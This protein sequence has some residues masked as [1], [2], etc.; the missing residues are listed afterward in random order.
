MDINLTLIGQSIA[1]IVFVYFCMKYIWP[2]IMQALE[3]RRQNV[4]DGIA[5]SDK[6]QTEL[7][8]ATEKSE[9]II[10]EARTRALEIMDQANQ[11]AN[12]VMADAK[13]DATVEGKRLVEA[14]HSEIEQESNRAKDSLRGEIASIAV[15]GASKLLDREVDEKT[16]AALLDKLVAEL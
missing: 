16:H 1:F 2:P 10:E 14:A 7:A 11:R 13:S 12:Q 6:A 4:A 8:A 9:A 3:E 15:A 5:A